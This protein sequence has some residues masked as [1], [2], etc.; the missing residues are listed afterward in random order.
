MRNHPFAGEI[1]ASLE[2]LVLRDGG[3]ETATCK[4]EQ[5]QAGA[6][7][8]GEKPTAGCGHLLAVEGEALAVSPSDAGR[9]SPTSAARR[10]AWWVRAW[11]RWAGLP[12]VDRVVLAA[13]P[14]GLQATTSTVAILAH[15]DRPTVL[16]ALIRLEHQGLVV[17]SLRTPPAGT[18]GVDPAACWWS[19]P[20]AVAA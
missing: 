8:S 10:E 18:R 12:D 5:G 17:R 20:E 15:L 3:D 4:G 11:R 16:H 6:S 1:I 19:L 9:F 2:E 13:V 7:L 14:A